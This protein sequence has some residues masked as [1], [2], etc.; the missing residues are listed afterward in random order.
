MVKHN[1]QLFKKEFESG[2][3]ASLKQFAVE[4]G[5]NENYLRQKAKDWSRPSSPENA[6]LEKSRIS[7]P[8]ESRLERAWDKLLEAVEDIDFSGDKNVDGLTPQ[9]VYQLS[10]TLERIQKG[11]HVVSVKKENALQGLIDAV[12]RAAKRAER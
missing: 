1:W 7:I 5:I 10:A 9:E 6:I 11:W 12:K 4:K 3:Y 2:Q 8:Y